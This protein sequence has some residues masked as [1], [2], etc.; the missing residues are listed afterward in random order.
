MNFTIQMTAEQLRT[1]KWALEHA[2]M[3]GYVPQPEDDL[4]A[5]GSHPETI[6]DLAKM[7]L[8]EPEADCLHGWAI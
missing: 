8:E 6:A 7:T 4:D 1:I 2:D 5:E 3:T